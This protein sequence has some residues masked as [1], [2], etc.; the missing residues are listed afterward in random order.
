MSFQHSL[1]NNLG[2]YF[3]TYIVI[4]CLYFSRLFK[5]ILLYFT[6]MEK[7]ADKDGE[8]MPTPTPRASAA[9]ARRAALAE[10]AANLAADTRPSPLDRSS[11][12]GDRT[13]G[14]D[15]SSSLSDRTSGSGLSDYTSKRLEELRLRRAESAADS[16]SDYRSRRE[17]KDKSDTGSIS[18]T[19]SSEY[20]EIKLRRERERERENNMKDRAKEKENVD[21]KPSIPSMTTPHVTSSTTSSLTSS[22]KREKPPIKEKPTDYRPRSENKVGFACNFDFIFT[23]SICLK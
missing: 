8:S 10:R 3:P 17:S 20:M 22:T 13:S 21:T 23:I 16:Y 12:L 14:L 15:R 19:G 6:D 7:D 11:A 1:F 18:S 2:L 4:K 9:A 5:K